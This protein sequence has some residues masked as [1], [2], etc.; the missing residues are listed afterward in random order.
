MIARRRA[1]NEAAAARLLA[2][3]RVCVGEDLKPGS[4]LPKLPR[5]AMPAAGPGVGPGVG[6]GIGHRGA[7][8]MAEGMA[9]GLAEGLVP[10]GHARWHER[11]DAAASGW[12]GSVGGCALTRRRARREAAG[13]DDA[14]H[15]ARE[16]LGPPLTWSRA[17][18]P[19]HPMGAVASAA[20]YAEK[21][22]GAWQGAPTRARVS[23]AVRPTHASMMR[24]ATSLPHYVGRPHGG[25]A[26]RPAPR[27]LL[28]DG[29]RAPQSTPD[30]DAARRQPPP[31]EAPV[32]A[33][34]ADAV[35]DAVGSSQGA[36]EVHGVQTVL[37]VAHAKAIEWLAD[38]GRAL[39]AGREPTAT[40]AEL[41]HAMLAAPPLRDA[42]HGAQAER[43]PRLELPHAAG[44]RRA[45]VSNALPL[46]E[47]PGP[48]DEADL[49]RFFALVTPDAQRILATSLGRSNR[50]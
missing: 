41:E 30:D 27:A 2:P 40:M 23:A 36:V 28:P 19:Y 12:E 32:L 39:A 7:E 48:L 49:A 4:A 21:D 42:Q 8:G 13:R 25:L 44:Q 38:G 24:R 47:L 34:G 50:T 11:W 9:E 29:G 45:P 1:E 37:C 43:L 31:G 18:T 46:S 6:P 26:A 5:G 16:A 33:P 17:Y 14:R 35:G 15:G 10:L 22:G 20:T 3:P